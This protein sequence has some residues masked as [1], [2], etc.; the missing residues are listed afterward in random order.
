MVKGSV[1]LI[2]QFWDRWTRRAARDPPGLFRKPRENPRTR[3]GDKA[4]PRSDRPLQQAPVR[5]EA[6]KNPRFW[7]FI[8]RIA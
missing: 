4:W 3:Q 2:A 5:F 1:W 7:S 6:A 8:F